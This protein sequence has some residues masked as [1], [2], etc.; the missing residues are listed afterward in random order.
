MMN[1]QIIN[2]VLYVKY[3]G[4]YICAN[5]K[6]DMDI[7]RQCRQLYAQG[8]VLAHRFHMC[9]D[10]V[11]ITLF[12]LF[13]AVYITTVVEIPSIVDKENVSHIIMPLE[14]CLDYVEIAARVECCH[15]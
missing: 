2:E 14:C 9:T 12:I 13:V 11:K 15:T 6:D 7:M 5:M 1:G 8:N 3:L 4:H 10:N